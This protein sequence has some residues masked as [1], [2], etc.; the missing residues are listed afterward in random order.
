[1]IGEYMKFLEDL[2]QE[3]RDRGEYD[4]AAKL[5]KTAWFLWE[6]WDELL[7]TATRVRT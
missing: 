5:N 1:M 3:F 2:E 6:T 4:K 7:K